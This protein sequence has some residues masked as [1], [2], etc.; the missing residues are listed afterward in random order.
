[1]FENKPY[2]L[3]HGDCLEIIKNIPDDSIDLAVIDPPYKI[4][5]GGCTNKA[6]KYTGANNED[7]K[8]GKV[9]GNNDISFKE[10][11]PLLYNKVKDGSHV[12]IM[13]NDRNMREL[14]NVAH[15]SNFKLLNILTWKKTKHNPNR[16]YLKNS[17]FI[18]M[19]RKGRAVNINNMGTFSVLEVPNVDKKVHPSDKPIDLMQILI[20]NSSKNN[21]I[22]L[23]CFMGGGSTGVACM[24][25]GRKFIGI[26]L[27]DT[28]FNIAESRISE[29]LANKEIVGVK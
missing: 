10:W 15:N 2:E 5:Q 1:M 24:N 19:F 29:T 3:Y 21:E 4:V 11:I 12:Y 18:C 16:Y 17:E 26:E 27:D 25:T 28:Y 9:F 8:K 6:V 22:V 7:L 13:C 23:D 14:L 20:E